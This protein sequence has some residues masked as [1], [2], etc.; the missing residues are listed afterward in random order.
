MDAGV[1]I[2]RP[3]A[4]I[5]M[6]L[7]KEN[8]KI[9]I[10]TDILGLEDHYGDMDF[11][12]AGSSQ[13][14]TAIQMD[15]K[16]AG[17]SKNTLFDILQKSKKARLFILN[18]MNEV[19]SEPRKDLSIY[20]PKIVIL[21]I[22]PNKI[23]IVIGPS[24]KNIKKIIEVTGAT[25]DIKEDGEIYISSINENSI[26]QAKKMIESITKEAKVG[27]MYKGKVTRTTNFGAFVEILPGKE[28]L[29][30]ISKLSHKHVVKVEDIVKVDDDILV[31]VIGIDNQGRI[32][33]RKVDIEENSIIE[34]ESINHNENYD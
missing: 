15:L 3:I 22:D 23:G 30:H 34:N 19:I 7:V 13:G 1:P 5:A 28:G 2:K 24:G 10:L 11:K 26:K 32:D 31:K 12:A 4:G 20:A 9:E 17:I 16:I 6:G 29:V 14:I 18:Q 25:I 8:E 33:L 27:D 21:K